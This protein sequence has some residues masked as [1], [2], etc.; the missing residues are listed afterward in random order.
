[1]RIHGDVW[2]VVQVRTGNEQDDAPDE[3]LVGNVGDLLNWA[4]QF[5]VDDIRGVFTRKRE[6]NKFAE[7]QKIK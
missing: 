6:A 1:M 7:R 5:G 2:F 3:I 4:G